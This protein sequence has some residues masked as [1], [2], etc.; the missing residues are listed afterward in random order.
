[1]R[2]KTGSIMVLI[3]VVRLYH[4]GQIHHT[5]RLHHLILYGPLLVRPAWIKM[6]VAVS[7]S[8]LL[9]QIIGL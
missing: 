7:I 3:G 2:D 9:L 4:Q 6:V 8:L 1:M 5:R